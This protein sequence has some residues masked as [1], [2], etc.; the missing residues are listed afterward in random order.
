[1]AK[2]VN[3]LSRVFLLRYN[4]SLHSLTVFNVLR[5]TSTIHEWVL[6]K[7]SLLK[8]ELAL[9]L[10]PVGHCPLSFF[11]SKNIYC[12]FSRQNRWP[13]ASRRFSSSLRFVKGFSKTQTAPRSFFIMNISSFPSSD[14]RKLLSL[15]AC[16]GSLHHSAAVPWQSPCVGACVVATQ[17]PL[18][19]LEHGSKGSSC[20]SQSSVRTMARLFWKLQLG[21]VFAGPACLC[22]CTRTCACPGL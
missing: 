18:A 3:H 15:C 2:N 22:V 21:Y 14:C 8:L 20:S 19:H 11:F 12:H 7:T 10:T 6:F 4:S 1:M 5:A 13:I 9:W 17:T 16:M